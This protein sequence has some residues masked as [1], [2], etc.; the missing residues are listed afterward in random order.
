[1]TPF[2]YQKKLMTILIVFMY[3]QLIHGVCGA[4]EAVLVVTTIERARGPD[5]VQTRNG[6]ALECE[7]K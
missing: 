3:I 6:N 5:R 4:R 7:M 1:M 2:G